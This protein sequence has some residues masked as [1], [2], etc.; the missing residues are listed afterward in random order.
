MKF[1]KVAVDIY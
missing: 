1:K